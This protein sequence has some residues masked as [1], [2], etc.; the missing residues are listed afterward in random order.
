MWIMNRHNSGLQKLEM[1]G[2]FQ[3]RRVFFFFLVL[4]CGVPSPSYLFAGQWKEAHNGLL[5]K[6]KDGPYIDYMNTNSCVCKVNCGTSDEEKLQPRVCPKE[7]GFYGFLKISS[8]KC[9]IE[10]NNIC[11]LLSA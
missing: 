2:N 11:N 1:G 4:F 7:S 9:K 5:K 8:T 3:W 10:G 6:K